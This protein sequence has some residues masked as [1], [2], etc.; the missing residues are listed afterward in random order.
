MRKKSAVQVK[1]DY[2]MNRR[3]F[4]GSSLASL[5][6]ACGGATL[7]L[8][9]SSNSEVVHYIFYDERFQAAEHLAKQITESVEAIPVQGDVTPVWNGELKFAC[10]ESALLLAGVTTESFYFCLK[11]LMQSHTGL[12]LSTD[13]ISQDLIAWSI[14]S[15]RPIGGRV[16]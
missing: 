9:G 7:A 16:S 2:L 13:R 11:T 1:S 8:S 12:A 3:D 5:T 15:Y 10:R 14:R 4:L 6:L